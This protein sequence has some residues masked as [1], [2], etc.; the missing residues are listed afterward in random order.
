MEHAVGQMAD[1]GIVPGVIVDAVGGDPLVV[2]PRG[3]PLGRGGGDD[4]LLP[5]PVMHG[6]GGGEG[7][8]PVFLGFVPGDGAELYR[9]GAGGRIGAGG[10]VVAL[11][12]VALYRKQCGV[13]RFLCRRDGKAGGILDSQRMLPLCEHIADVRIVVRRRGR[14]GN[15]FP[16]RHEI[17]VGRAL[18]AEKVSEVPVRCQP[19]GRVHDSGQ[20]GR[21]RAPGNG[22][23]GEKR[24]GGVAANTD[25]AAVEL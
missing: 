5:Q 4:A 2:G 22:S 10:V 14:G 16:N 9:H 6:D 20:H 3:L 13:Q 18:G 25:A 15:V 7:L 12:T 24:A 8:R 23:V 17:L 11:L 1:G 21:R 19:Q